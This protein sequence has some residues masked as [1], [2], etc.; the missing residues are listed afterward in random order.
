M[1][2]K[3]KRK[4]GCGPGIDQLALAGFATNSGQRAEPVSKGFVKYA[5]QCL[6]AGV[7]ELLGV[8]F[9]G[10]VY[11]GLE[12]K[13]TIQSSGSHHY[14]GRGLYLFIYLFKAYLSYP[15]T[16]LPAACRT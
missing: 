7:L 3:S 1:S 2:I 11:A 6:R 10:Y 14:G 9:P 16:G 4:V 13:T 5:S 15:S 12:N 8:K